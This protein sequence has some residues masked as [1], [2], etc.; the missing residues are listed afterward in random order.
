MKIVDART[1]YGIKLYPGSYVKDVKTREG[2]IEIEKIVLNPAYMYACDCCVDGFYQ[3]YLWSKDKNYVIKLG[4]YNPKCRV[5]PEIEITRQLER[6]IRGLV[7]H[8]LHH[9]YSLLDERVHKLLN[10]VNDYS[11]PLFIFKPKKE[12]LE[13]IIYEISVP[14]VLIEVDYILP[15]DSVYYEVNANSRIKPNAKKAIYGSG[16]PYNGKNAIESAKQSIVTLGYDR[17]IFYE[18]LK[19]ILS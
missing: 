14:V 6:G 19:R 18:N 8:P 9:N 15:Y 11:L 12:E 17:D 3:Q 16:A 1:H 2:D 13:K 10:I 4:M 5:P 7:L